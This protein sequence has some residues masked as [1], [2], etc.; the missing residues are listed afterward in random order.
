MSSRD[1]DIYPGD[2]LE[3]HLNIRSLIINEIVSQM[4]LWRRGLWVL[5]GTF[6]GLVISF[7]LVTSALLLSGAWGQPGPGRAAAFLV[8]P[9]ATPTAEP[10]P[11]SVSEATP[12]QVSTLRPSNAATSTP[13][14]TAPEAKPTAVST[15]PAV[16]PTAVPP[17]RIPPTSTDLPAAPPPSCPS[18]P[19]SGYATDLFSAINRARNAQGISSLSAHGCAVYVAQLRSDDMASIGYFS[20]TSPTGDTAFSLLDA[21]LVP[22]GWAGENLARN[23]Y[24]D[25]ESVGVAIRDLMASDGHRA[26]I[27][28]ANYTSLG[29]AV[30][31]DGEGM[32]YFTMVF[33]GPP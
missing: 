26:N 6:V 18:A 25:N 30:A 32:K 17:T 1:A 4:R 24:P 5:R 28:S 7:T 2:S 27:L 29:V 8:E 14:A 21:F 10:T 31:F 20:H 33:M 16:A 13:V 22:H 9:V 12:T 19:L 23:N 3:G 11:T 15:R